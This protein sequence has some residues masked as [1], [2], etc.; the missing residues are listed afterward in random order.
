MTVQIIENLTTEGRLN[1]QTF[2]V[3]CMVGLMSGIR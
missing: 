1:G 3:Q 2:C